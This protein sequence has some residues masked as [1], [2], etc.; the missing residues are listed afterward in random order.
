[1][2]G[3]ENDDDFVFDNQMIVQAAAFGFRIAE[4]TCPTKYFDD[5]SSISFAR[6]VKSGLGVLKAAAE[7]RLKRMG[8]IDPSD[9]RTDGRKLPAAEPIDD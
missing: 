8:V 7:L 9:L 3:N 1:M 6:S 4:V 5:A 2:L